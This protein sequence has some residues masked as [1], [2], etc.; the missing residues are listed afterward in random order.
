MQKMLYMAL[1]CCG[2]LPG[3]C[4]VLANMAVAHYYVFWVVCTIETLNV[5]LVFR[6]VGLGTSFSASLFFAPFIIQQMEIVS[7]KS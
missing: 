4:C 2:C 6:S 1:E 7:P 3:H 5:S